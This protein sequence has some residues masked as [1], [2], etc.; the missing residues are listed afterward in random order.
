[1]VRGERI[2]VVWPDSMEAV[3]GTR[4]VCLGDTLEVLGPSG[5]GKTHVMTQIATQ[6]ATHTHTSVVYIDLDNRQQLSTLLPASVHVFQPKDSVA[7]EATLRGLDQ[8]MQTSHGP[9]CVCIDG[10]VER[11]EPALE[12]QAHWGYVLVTSCKIRRSPGSGG[13]SSGDYS[14]GGHSGYRF[15]VQERHILHAEAF[16]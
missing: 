10:T 4:G 6:I 9:V 7:A 13:H 16:Q 11:W 3:V 1:M 14:S 8:W 12:C 5:S 2:P 15:Q